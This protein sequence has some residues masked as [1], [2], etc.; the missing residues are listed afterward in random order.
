MTN[1]IRNHRKGLLISLGCCL[2]LL[3][4]G[5]ALCWNDISRLYHRGDLIDVEIARKIGIGNYLQQE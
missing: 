4:A 2:L 5:L 3:V 1:W